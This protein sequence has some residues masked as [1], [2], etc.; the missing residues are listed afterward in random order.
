MFWC[1]IFFYSFLFLFFQ[2][3]ELNLGLAHELHLQCS[4]KSIFILRQD[5][6]KAVN[7]PEWYWI[8]SSPASAFSSTGVVFLISHDSYLPSLFPASRSSSGDLILDLN[9]IFQLLVNSSHASVLECCFSFH[10]K[11]KVEPSLKPPAPWYS[12]HRNQAS[13]MR[14]GS[15][16]H[17]LQ[18]TLKFLPFFS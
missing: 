8:C 10:E 16:P 3:Q 13:I 5:V 18:H 14:Q 7:C 1:L 4:K 15:N 11:Y 12:L 9:S 6:L 17:P 2:C